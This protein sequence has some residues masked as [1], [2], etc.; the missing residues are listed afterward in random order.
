ME[1]SN[2]WRCCVSSPSNWISFMISAWFSKIN[3][4]T[5]DISICTYFQIL[6]TKP[7]NAFLSRRN[8]LQFVLKNALFL[9]TITRRN[10]RRE[11]YQMLLT[12]CVWN[13]RSISK[14]RLRMSPW[15][16]SWNEA[17]VCSSWCW[18]QVSCNCVSP[19]CHQ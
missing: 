17:R 13:W 19:P 18:V 14:W 5:L 7:K 3:L 11:W 16:E 12:S 4:I 1:P 15:I 10:E 6:K 8:R 9:K 2:W